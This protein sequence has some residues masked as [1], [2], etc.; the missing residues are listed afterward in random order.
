MRDHCKKCVHVCITK[1]FCVCFT[2]Y[3]PCYRAGLSLIGRWA[4]SERG[5]PQWGPQRSH[6][7]N[8]NHKVE[9]PQRVRASTLQYNEMK[10]RR[11]G[12]R[13]QRFLFR[14]QFAVNLGNKKLFL[15]CFVFLFFFMVFVLQT[16]NHFL[17]SISTAT[18]SFWTRRPPPFHFP[19]LPVFPSVIIL[20]SD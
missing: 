13:G 16:P 4:N 3:N 2:L 6:F 7:Y 12:Q 11:E 8:L 1:C 18:S 10:Q 5:L 15:Y 19:L 9:K 17:Y 20:H 14:H